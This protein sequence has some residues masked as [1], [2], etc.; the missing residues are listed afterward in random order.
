MLRQILAFGLAVCS[1]ALPA[2]QIVFKD[3]FFQVVLDNDYVRV[4]R[5]ADML[6]GKMVTPP[7]RS[8]RDYV[9]IIFLAEKPS[10]ECKGLVSRT[11]FSDIYV[12]YITPRDESKRTRTVARC[13]WKAVLID[14]KSQPPPTPFA[15]DAVKLDPQHNLVLFENDRVR[16]VRVHFDLG[17]KGPVVDKRPRVIILVTDMHAEVAKSGGAPEARDGTAGTIYWSLGGSQATMNRNET[18]LD[19]I[20]VELKG[21]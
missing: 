12:D 21:K 4:F 18:K 19:N 2:K 14:L 20:V 9:R 13:R 3:S 17:E 11:S 15:L 5:Q 16:V 10:E 8:A 7:L 1:L 6:P